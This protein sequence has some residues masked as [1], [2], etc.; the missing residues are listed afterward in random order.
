L[1]WIKKEEQTTS[2]KNPNLPRGL[3]HY[4]DCLHR[5]EDAKYLIFANQTTPFPGKGDAALVGSEVDAA[6]G[7]PTDG[8]TTDSLADTEE[9]SCGKR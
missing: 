4:K 8:I 6:G 1:F 5:I 3:P 2:L 9:E 7:S